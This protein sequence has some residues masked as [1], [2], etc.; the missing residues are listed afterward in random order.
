MEQTRG[1][2]SQRLI[3]IIGAANNKIQLGRGIEATDHIAGLEF[4]SNGDSHYILQDSKF[5]TYILKFSQHDTAA[6][7]HPLHRKAM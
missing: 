4:F 2:F 5:R 6:Q 1:Q 3:I 7:N